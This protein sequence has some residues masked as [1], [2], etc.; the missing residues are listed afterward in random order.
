MTRWNNSSLRNP[1]WVSDSFFLS[2]RR[3]HQ[4]QISMSRLGPAP[5]SLA[6]IGRFRHDMRAEQIGQCEIPARF[7]P[8][9]VQAAFSS[10]KKAASVLDKF[11]HGGGLRTGHPAKVRQN[12]RG[13]LG[14]VAF[15]VVRVNG[16]IRNAGAD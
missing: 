11:S 16:E 2:S 5:A 13:E 3:E 15:D 12:Q 1:V 9:V 8:F 4:P 7:A 10:G 6:K 14:R